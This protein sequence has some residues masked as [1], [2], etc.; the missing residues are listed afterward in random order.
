MLTLS[1]HREPS[2]AEDG[3]DGALDPATDMPD[4]LEVRSLCISFDTAEGEVSAVDGV[5]FGVERGSVTALVGE[6]GCGKT[7][8]AMSVLRLLPPN[9]RYR[10]GEI[11]FDGQDL[12]KT[13]EPGLQRVR[14]RRI[15][16]V[17]QEP[18]TALNPVLPVG[19]Q[20]AEVIE[21][22]SRVS[23]R[24]AD[25]RAIEVLAGVA[26]PDPRRV[27]GLYPHELSGGM[28][29][30]VMIAVALAGE[31]ELIIADEPTTALDVTIQAQ[32]LDLLKLLVRE[33]GVAVMMIT[34]DFGVVA[35]IADR[36]AVMYAGRVV[37][38][39]PMRQVLSAARHPYTQALLKCLTSVRERHTRLA[40]IPGM[41][42]SMSHMPT[43]CRFHPRCELGRDD[44]Q[45]REQSPELR[46]IADGRDVACWK[47]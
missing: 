7:V 31:P 10:R 8:T 14:G 15:G 13:D 18:M 22:H 24:Q 19:R 5:S 4:L 37:E 36:V 42:P 34:H 27:A 40:V 32:I 39:G 1:D 26:L 35:A 41:V 30:R 46:E 23:R 11:I 43:G 6:S 44:A 28:R 20:V 25:R 3:K 21:H 38:R 47:A 2:L 17:F 12:L 29:Q 33:R 9:A 16:M 45:C